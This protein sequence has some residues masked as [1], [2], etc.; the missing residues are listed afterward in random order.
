MKILRQADDEVQAGAGAGDE[1]QA[2]AAAGDQVQA[3]ADAGDQVQ[4]GAGDEEKA[5]EK[6]K[7][8]VR[9]AQPSP[10]VK[11]AMA[12]WFRE[13]PKQGAWKVGKVVANSLGKRAAEKLKKAVKDLNEEEFEA[14]CEGMRASKVR[15]VRKK[16]VRWQAME[17]GLFFFCSFLF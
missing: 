10:A 15:R 1:V 13:N 17:D 5:G 3:G 9:K 4:A 16:R 12:K 8:K 11:I 14:W 7:V 6:K 2:V